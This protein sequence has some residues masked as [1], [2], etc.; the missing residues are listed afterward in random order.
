[1]MKIIPELNAA[2]GRTPHEEGCGPRARA[3]SA[4]IAELTASLP[5][6]VGVAALDLVEGATRRCPPDGRRGDV[7]R[8]LGGAS[9]GHGDF[10]AVVVRA[11]RENEVPV[12]DS[13]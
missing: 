5:V 10:L 4:T 13:P 8:A 2:P 6:L 3:C 7:G 12:H 1:M 11:G 9:A